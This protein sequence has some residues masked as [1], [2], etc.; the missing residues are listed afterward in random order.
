[1]LNWSISLFF[2]LAN[3]L[4]IVPV[5]LSMVLTMG[6]PSSGLANLSLE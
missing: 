1:M 4:V 2:L 5:S 3:I 6:P